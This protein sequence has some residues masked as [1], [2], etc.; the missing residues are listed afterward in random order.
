MQAGR[1]DPEE[2]AREPEREARLGLPGHLPAV[3]GIYHPHRLARPQVPVVGAGG[4]QPGH[5]HLAG[6]LIA[7]HVGQDDQQ[8]EHGVTG[9]E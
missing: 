5:G 6:P 1:R 7:G 4:Q 2:S 8:R 9:P 3:Q